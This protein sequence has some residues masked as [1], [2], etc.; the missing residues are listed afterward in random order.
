MAPSA[1]SFPKG[2]C[3]RGKESVKPSRLPAQCTTK[4]SPLGLQSLLLYTT[5]LTAA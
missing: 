2:P 4:L 3:H 1:D 5:T